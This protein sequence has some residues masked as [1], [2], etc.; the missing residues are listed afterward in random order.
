MTH[1]EGPIVDSF[2]D[3]C[4]TSWHKEFKPPLPCH[5]SPA[6]PGGFPS[7]EQASHSR[8]FDENGNVHTELHGDGLNG[9]QTLTLGHGSQGASEGID[10]RSSNNALNLASV[11]SDG[12]GDRLPEHTAIDPHYDVD[13]VAEVRRSQSVLKPREGESRMNCVTR[14]LNTT[15]QPNT[16]GSAPECEPGQEMTPLIP[17]PAHEPVPMAMVCRKPWGAPNH[18]CVHTPQNEAFL[19]C[20][21]NARK[22]VFIQTPN[23]NA[24]PLLPAIIAAVKR[25]VVVTYYVCLGYND[26][27]CSLQYLYIHINFLSIHSYNPS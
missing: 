24:G 8:M 6:A 3:V 5:N 7:F 27:V 15:I 26:A 9:Q 22:T 20:L 21:R 4:L 23:L 18:S 11:V 10:Q 16:K 17:H 1:L 25:K 12:T 14:H 13:I 19:S 2:Y